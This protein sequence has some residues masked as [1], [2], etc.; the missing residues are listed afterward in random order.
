M[1]PVKT[2]ELNGLFVWLTYLVCCSMSSSSL[3]PQAV[4]KNIH[5]NCHSNVISIFVQMSAQIDRVGRSMVGWVGVWGGKG[6]E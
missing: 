5:V 2:M 3:R 6:N 4:I 1:C